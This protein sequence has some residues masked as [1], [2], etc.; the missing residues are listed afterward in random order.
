MTEF[1][2][3]S[4]CVS[5]NSLLSLRPLASVSLHIYKHFCY[6]DPDRNEGCPVKP[7]GVSQL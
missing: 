7:K 6:K 5:S 4:R 2:T 3:V 1:T